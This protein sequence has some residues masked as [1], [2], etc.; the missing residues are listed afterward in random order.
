[1]TSV[2]ACQTTPQVVS[3]VPPAELLEDC[4]RRPVRM[5]TNGDLVVAYAI[6]DQDLD[7]CNADKAALRV[8]RDSVSGG[9]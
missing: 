9:D 4:V 2:G 6:R 7:I 8:W 5:E 3:V 1:M